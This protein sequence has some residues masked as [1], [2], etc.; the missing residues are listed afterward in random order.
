MIISKEKSIYYDDVNLLAQPCTVKSRKDIPKELWRLIVSPMSSIVGATLTK[1]AL[2]LGLTVC[3]HRFQTVE[4]QLQSVA[5][6]PNEYFNRI[7]FAVGLNDTE[8]IKRL[9]QFG[10]KNWLIDIAQGYMHEE[11]EKTLRQLICTLSSQAG[12]SGSKRIMVGNVHTAE[13]FKNLDFKVDYSEMLVRIGIGNGQLCLTKDVTGFNRGQF[14]ELNEV[15]EEQIRL[16]TKTKIVADG[17]INGAANALKA[18]GVG[19]DGV[20]MGSFFAQAEEAECNVQGHKSIWGGASLKQARLLGKVL[21][22]SEG[23]ESKVKGEIKPLKELINELW[24]GISSGI[25][26]SGYE[27]LSSFISRG[28]FE[29]KA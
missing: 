23:K 6:I 16:N 14:T 12:L 19:A 2:D 8:R 15:V 25:S 13:G 29:L 5:E 17:N 11:I 24:S 1:S 22:H 3:V 4:E 26:Y 28:V 9:I 18:F 20:M 27:S 7:F 10:N 21:G